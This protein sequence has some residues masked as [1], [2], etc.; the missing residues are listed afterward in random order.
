MQEIEITLVFQG[1]YIAR[2]SSVQGNK[3]L[4]LLKPEDSFQDSLVTNRKYNKPSIPWKKLLPGAPFSWGRRSVYE[5]L[6]QKQ[7]QEICPLSRPAV[8]TPGYAVD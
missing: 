7:D 4:W 3:N 6:S 5:E 8:H 1:S 2:E